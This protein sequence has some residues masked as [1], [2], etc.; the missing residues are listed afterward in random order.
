MLEKSMYDSWASRIRLFIKGKKH[1]RM[2]LD[3]I[4]NGSLVYLTVEEDG[5]TRPKKYSKLTEVQQ[6][7]D[8]CDIQVTN[9][10]LHGLPHDKKAPATTDKIEGIDLL[11]EVALL[12]DAQMKK[13]LKPSKR[14]TYSLQPSGSG[15]GVG[16][17]TKVPDEPKESGDDDDGN[18]D[19]N[20]DDGSDT[21]SDNERTESNKDENPNLNQN[22]DDI[23]EEYVHTLE[24]Y[25]STDDENEYVNEE[26]YDRIDEELYKDVNMKLKDVEHREERKRDAE[27]TDAGHDDVT[28]ETSYDQ[29]EDDAHVTLTAVHDTQ[30]TKVPLQ[31]SSISSDFATQF[32]NMD[33]IPPPNTEINSMMNIDVCHEEPSNQTPSLLTKPVT[34]IPKTLT[35]T[36]TTIPPPI[37]SFIPLP[38][39]STLTSTPR[40]KATTSL[41]AIPDFSSLFGFNQRVS[42]LPKEVS[43]FATLVIHSTITESIENVIV[44]KYSSQPQSTYEAAASLIELVKSYK[45]DKDLFESY[46]KAY[47]LIR[48]CE[49]KDKDEDPPAGSDQGLKR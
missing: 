40:T 5:H 2:M 25:E 9:I 14:E 16:P 23:E 13:V 21:D 22:N 46:G 3:S 19:D 47:S 12:K 45:L 49:D 36:A 28:Q 35:A 7:Q 38:Q 11:F 39:Q 24:N 4:D 37:P 1:G 33:N 31:S 34:V 27:K 10:I 8:D 15:D 26:E 6:L 43:D 30:K 20:D 41:P 42:I 44:A 18:D 32:L 17:Q 29:V 48:D